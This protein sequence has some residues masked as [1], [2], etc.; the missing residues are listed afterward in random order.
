M[1]IKRAVIALIVAAV[2]IAGAYANWWAFKQKFPY[3]SF[4]AWVIAPR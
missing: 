2:I 3:A 4:W 1:T